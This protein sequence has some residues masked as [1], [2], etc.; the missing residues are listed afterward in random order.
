MS[1]KDLKI[2]TDL[3]SSLL[4]FIIDH[5]KGYSED[6]M[7]FL[8][9]TWPKAAGRLG[10]PRQGVSVA[11]YWAFM[12]KVVMND[13]DI[14]PDM[15][16]PRRNREGDTEK[17]S[18]MFRASLTDLLNSLRDPIKLSGAFN[19]AEGAFMNM[20]ATYRV[21]LGQ[22]DP[23]ESKVFRKTLSQLRHLHAP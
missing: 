20:V 3:L 12:K 18:Q 17:P 6:D 14:T 13:Y 15:P 9:R 8:I 5:P 21:K 23:E 2:V 7:V 22:S 11:A 10:Q 1:D 19:D 16:L 4:R